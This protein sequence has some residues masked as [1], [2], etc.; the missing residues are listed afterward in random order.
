MCIH[1]YSFVS[2][3]GISNSTELTSDQANTTVSQANTTEAFTTVDINS[4][5][6]D[7]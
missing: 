2:F 3:I 6:A 1:M 4:K 5:Y 7:R